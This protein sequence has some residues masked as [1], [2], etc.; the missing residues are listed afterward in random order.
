MTIA[1][2]IKGALTMEGKTQIELAKALGIS[3]QAV[4]NKMHRNSFSSEDLIKIATF[5]NYNLTMEK[6]DKRILFTMEDIE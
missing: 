2:K 5:L 4:A 1:N 3:P 6:D